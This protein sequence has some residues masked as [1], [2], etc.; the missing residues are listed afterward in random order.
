MRA[1]AWL[2]I[3]LRVVIPIAWIVAAVAATLALPSLGATGSTPL[4]D[5]VAQG[6]AAGAQQQYAIA[7]F[8][9][10]LYTDTAVV[11]RDPRG[12]PPG[13]QERTARAALAVD[14][15]RTRDL[16]N[17]RAVLPI[18][19]AHGSPLVL[20]ADATTAV[21]YLYFA[22]RANLNERTAT[23][24][25][26]GQR[27]LGGER[28]AVIG[29]TGAA[30]ARLAQFNEI[31]SALPLVTVAS[32]ALILIVVGL[33]F[34][35]LG[36]PLVALSA[37]AIAYL[38][39]VRLLPWLGQRAGAT[40]P[41]E[42]EPIVVVLL[43]GLV[44][45]YSVFYLSETRRRLRLGESRL[46]A[47]RAA[48]AR[49]TPIVF[50]AGL[51]VAAG[52]GALVVGKLGFFR[53]FGPGLAATTLIALAVAMTL[54]PA[55]IALFGTRLFGKDVKAGASEGPVPHT[56]TDTHEI[57]RTRKTVHAETP[58]SSAPSAR[59]RLTRPLLALR[60]TKQL[61]QQAQTT[62]W[63]VLIA[64]V[65]TAPPVAL[66]ITVACLAL[67]GVL[68]VHVRS[69]Q[70]GLGFLN[71]AAARQPGA[72]GVHRRERRVRARRALADRDRPGGRRHRDAAPR[73]RPAGGRAAPGAGRRR[74]DRPGRAAGP[75]GAADHGRAGRERRA[76]GGDL[77]FR[78]ARRARDPQARGAQ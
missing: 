22:N 57:E 69:T 50:T 24:H 75:A 3:S 25:H 65:A 47:A 6:G 15:Q 58:G 20:G 48:I 29:P 74:R 64:R 37:A 72:R 46:D 34:R 67:L 73:A 77:R 9:F 12:L 59:L 63:R 10:P 14:Q 36:A 32:V 23:A 43:L 51:I 62:R 68:A 26:Y 2:L 76:A 16:P 13:A 56:V 21:S 54:V 1:Y 44:T 19:N 53:A 61:A 30:P 40:V 8:G 28:G 35:S 17:L 39:A 11:A 5:L 42:V 60:R 4:D 27:Y 38:I 18:S 66:V 78:P 7:H 49:T 55:L 41:A 52:T 33:A 45:D 31:E 71:G 70:L